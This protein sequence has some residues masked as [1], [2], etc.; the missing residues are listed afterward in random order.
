MI[1]KHTVKV[2]MP[3]LKRCIAEES[4][5]VAD[6][7]V[8]LM[9]PRK[10]R[11]DDNDVAGVSGWLVEAGVTPPV[12]RSLRER[13]HAPPHRLVDS[14]PGSSINSVQLSNTE[15]AACG[16]F[17]PKLE[18]ISP[19]FQL[20]YERRK[21]RKGTSYPV[22]ET[23]TRGSADSD[24]LVDVDISYDTYNSNFSSM[25]HY[26]IST[27]VVVDIEGSKCLGLPDVGGGGRRGK[28]CDRGHKNRGVLLEEDRRDACKL[29]MFRVGDI[30]WAKLGRRYPAWPAIVINPLTDAPDVVLKCCIADALCVMYFGFSKNKKQREY[31]WVKRGMIFPFAENLRRFE[32]QSQMFNFRTDDFQMAI[33]EAVLAENGLLDANSGVLPVACYSQSKVK[34]AHEKD[35]R[36]CDECGATLPWTHIRRSNSSLS[37][38]LP[39]CKPCSELQKSKQHC[40]ICRKIWDPCDGGSWVCCGYCNVWVHAE[41]DNISDE[42]FEEFENGMYHCPNCRS[43][44]NSKSSQLVKGKQKVMINNR[45]RKVLPERLVVVCNGMEGIYFPSLHLVQCKC[46]SCGTK[47]ITLNEWERHTGC[48]AKKW[49]YSVKVKDAKVPLERW[50]AEYDALGADPSKL[51]TEQ[52]YSF[53]RETYE[54]VTAKWTSE[55]C[56]VCR[57]VEDSDENKIIICIRCQI[58]VHQECYG[59]RNVDITSWVCRVC[60][61]PEVERDCCLCPVKGGALKPTD[62]NTLWVHVT[63]AWLRP[64]VGFLDDG[65]MEPAVGILRIP[66]ISFVKACVICKRTRGSCIQCCKCATHFHA[67]CAARAGYYMELQCHEKNGV[68]ITRKLAYCAT[69]RTPNPEN[70]LV[71]HTPAGVFSATNMIRTP[72][73]ELNI[74]GSRKILTQ[75]KESELPVS[76]VEEFESDSAARCR[77]YRRSN[78]KKAGVEAVFHRLMGPRHHSL[79]EIERLNSSI[80]GNP[81]TF[82]S[83]KERLHHLQRTEKYRIGFGKSGIHGWG[84]FARREIQEGEMVFEYRGELLRPGIADRREAKYRV[85]GKDCYLFK[86]SKDVV[87]DATYRGSMGRLINHSCMPNC[88]ARIMNVSREECTIV[89]IAKTNLAAGDELTYDYM[90][91]P[92][93]K[94]DDKVP[95]L[96]KAPN[97]KKFMN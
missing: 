69:H 51:S 63:C 76:K 9:N 17:G 16:S 47:K 42:Y 12:T 13:V 35:T 31:S 92:D 19:S 81:N 54:P 36:A 15:V 52:L 25:S 58:A 4:L 41:C 53:L 57:W 88:F 37:Q 14:V 38:R 71:I 75:K 26:V 90:F 59:A 21:L 83:F 64:E 8:A 91:D 86:I 39:L 93:E 61:T 95:C 24:G 56:A 84:L 30:V 55:R 94:E 3:S 77:V 34:D 97:C 48:R 5:S 29:A 1:L 79:D 32:G 44:S 10:R 66:V 68:P 27:S 70:A 50:L 80:L 96:C 67:V 2:E 82:S 78:N 65:K 85:K 89:I 23:T 62:I 11:R 49:K 40:G 6:E 22:Q 60:E 45:E 28:E 18:R 87:V 7:E 73:K 46:G 33:D 43:K 74:R 72:E 20:V